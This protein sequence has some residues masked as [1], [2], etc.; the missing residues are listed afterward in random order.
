MVNTNKIIAGWKCSHCDDD[1]INFQGSLDWN[2][3]TN[4]FEYSG[5][6][7]D[8]YCDSCGYEV[9][10]E[11]VYQTVS[12]MTEDLIDDALEHVFSEAHHAFGTTTGDISPN[13]VFEL[14]ELKKRL[15]KLIAT[16]VT[17]NLGED[18][19]E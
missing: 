16:Q 2:K 12:Q 19:E 11:P 4:T 15:T 13:Q 7:S 9:P 6:L 3:K 18:N 17:Q 10:T 14:R 5:S 8:S 1:I